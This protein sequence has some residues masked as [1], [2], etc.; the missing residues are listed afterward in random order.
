ME[1]EDLYEL[2]RDPET[3]T[4]LYIAHR[5]A[6]SNNQRTWWHGQI[7]EFI[8][9]TKEF[10]VLYEDVGEPLLHPGS[11]PVIFLRKGGL[12]LDGLFRQFGTVHAAAPNIVLIDIGTNDLG[13]SCVPEELAEAENG[14]GPAPMESMLAWVNSSTT[15]SSDLGRSGWHQSQYSSVDPLEI[16]HIVSTACTELVNWN[17]FINE[18]NTDNVH[19]FLA[20]ASDTDDA[21]GVLR[22]NEKWRSSK[23]A[24][25]KTCRLD[26]CWITSH[27]GPSGRCG[28]AGPR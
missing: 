1:C 7:L 10:K 19:T 4:G 11:T 13:N 8:N 12:P 22:G 3:L 26:A 15:G 21:G 5:W 17:V 24:A 27:S 18:G 16:M 9:D 20:N 28:C 6:D 25:P 2:I 23:T 14:C